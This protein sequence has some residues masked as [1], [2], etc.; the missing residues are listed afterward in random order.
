MRVISDNV[1]K[2]ATLSAL[3]TAGVL[4][5]GNILSTDKTEVYQS[6][7]TTARIEAGW[8]TAERISAV[9]L[10]IC[11][12][13]PSALWRVRANGEGT[14]T[15]YAKYSESFSNAAWSK[16][17]STIGTTEADAAG[18]K[19]P[20]GAGGVEK[21][22]EQTGS[23]KYISQVWAVPA[24]QQVTVSFFVRAAERT[25][26]AIKFDNT[27]NT[28]A[29]F[30]SRAFFDLAAGTV[31]MDVDGGWTHGMQN[32]GNG[33]WRVWATRTTTAA[34]NI[35]P[36]LVAGSLNGSGQPVLLYTGIAGYGFY[37]WG[38]QFEYGTISSYYPNNTGGTSTRPLGYS[39]N[40][41]Q[42]SSFDSG[43][44]VAAPAE[45]IVLDGWTVAQSSC[46]YTY[47]G[48]TCAEMWIPEML[49]AYLII[50]IDDPANP[51]GAINI[52]QAVVGKYWETKYQPSDVTPRI[53]DSSEIKRTNAGT[54]T[55]RAG[56]IHKVL[57]IK[58]SMMPAQ[59]RKQFVRM[60]R[61]SRINPIYVSV[62]PGHSDSELARDL[63]IFGRRA[64][65]S[66]IELEFAEAYSTE[67]TIEEV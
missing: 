64:E 47:G 43:W 37:V 61:Q 53:A 21:F 25:L 48:G 28:A 1:L 9:V 11:G 58:L 32:I 39:D 46:A 23:E 5:V 57:P 35:V 19:A 26:V 44:K 3:T 15:N 18:V 42:T 54:Q 17:S 62:F 10:P 56:T 20:S 40:W 24:G 7:G 60:V 51:I 6:V 33:W 45:Q 14:K 27:A 59:D 13:S 38:A 36:R 55:G 41:Q 12:L 4:S 16:W 31:T 29:P 50:E 63:T 65:D 49:C 8:N 22:K 67:L 52:A 2:R 30:G 34:G 66:D